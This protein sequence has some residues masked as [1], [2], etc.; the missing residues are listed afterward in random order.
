[1]LTADGDDRSGA[2]TGPKERSM[3]RVSSKGCDS[4]YLAPGETGLAHIDRDHF[5]HAGVEGAEQSGIGLDRN[6]LPAALAHH[7]PADASR[8]VAAG[9]DLAAVLVVDAHEDVG[10]PRRALQRDHLVEAD[11]ITL[12]EGADR[13]RRQPDRPLARVEHGKSIA[14]AVHLAEGKRRACH[15]FRAGMSGWASIWRKPRGIASLAGA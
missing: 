3:A 7:Q 2:S 8:G 4:G 6:R 10:V 14:E 13:L 15:G 1:M 12:A 9:V 5:R 11:R